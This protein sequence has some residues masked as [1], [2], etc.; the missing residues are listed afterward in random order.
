[1]R[2]PKNGFVRLLLHCVVG[3]ACVA[4]GQRPLQAQERYTPHSP[5]VQAMVEKGV[6]FIETSQIRDIGPVS[7]HAIAICEAWKRY[8]NGE[9]PTDN[10][11]VVRSVQSASGYTLNEQGEATDNNTMYEPCVAS[12]LLG[13]VDPV[14]YAPNIKAVLTL[15]ENRQQPSGCWKYKAEG[16]SPLLGDTSQTQYSCLATWMAAKAG[17]QVKPEM[18]EKALDWLA[19]TQ[20]SQGGWAYRAIASDQGSGGGGE[21]LSMTAAGAGGMY[22]LLDAVDAKNVFGPKGAKRAGADLPAFITVY[23][24][25]APEAAEQAVS[26]KA[27]I[28]TAVVTACMSSAGQ[29]FG[30]HFVPDPPE[31]TYY[32]LYGFERYAYFREQADGEVREIP[33]WYD[34]GVDFLRTQQ[35]ADG[36]WRSGAS[37]EQAVTP[38]VTTAFA[39]LFLVRSTELLANDPGK[40]TLS[41]GNAI[42]KGNLKQKGQQIFGENVNAEVNDFLELVAAGDDKSIEMFADSLTTMVFPTDPAKRDLYMSKL[43]VLI[44]DADKFKVLVAVKALGTVRDI[45]NAPVL[46][47]AMK[48]D[49]D[50]IKVAAHRGLRFISRKID[51]IELPEKPTEGD[52]ITARKQWIE[53]YNSIR[54]DDKLEVE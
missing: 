10:P 42:P 23:T 49:E 32:Y 48:D 43:R 54:P 29:F 12:I 26:A 13:I 39:V 30:Q 44:T 19:K 36:S 21:T 5:E 28:D 25:D 18:I 14:K 33:D 3:L 11:I 24:P 53:W 16:G 9:L 45:N 38:S 1:M 35:G 2:S 51:S 31:W 4:I 15:I 8:H 20:T 7:L 37:G 17:Q 41:G 34:R 47:L 52:F 46:I 50:E 6:A 40:G 22:M 27:N